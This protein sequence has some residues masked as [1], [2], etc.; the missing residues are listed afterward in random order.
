MP[1]LSSSQPMIL[2]PGVPSTITNNITIHVRKEKKV[3]VSFTKQEVKL[4]N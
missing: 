1:T 3:R 2:Q 4:R